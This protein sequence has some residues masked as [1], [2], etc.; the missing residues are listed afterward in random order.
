MS[1]PS[2]LLSER[3]SAAPD[4]R[5]R[6]RRRRKRSIAPRTAL[7]SC[8]TQLTGGQNDLKD[9]SV[10]IARRRADAAIVSFDDRPAN[11][12]TY[13]HA[14]GLRRVERLKNAVDPF[15]IDTR[16]RVFHR[17]HY[18]IRFARFR[19]HPQNAWALRYGAHGIDRVRNQIQED[20]LQLD[21][22]AQDLKRFC[23]KFGL[24]RNLLVLQL[25]L[26][27]RE[28]L[29]DQLVQVDRSSFLTIFLE[30]RSDRTDNLARTMTV[31]DDAR[32]R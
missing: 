21:A 32:Q 1:Q 25:A 7:S 18:A 26:H 2:I 4:V 10:R 11:S 9:R 8:S 15:R 14:L 19:F 3:G 17:D 5:T 24:E 6:H 31:V 13:A 23:F 28:D 29:L 27:K 12:Q 16:P 20:L 30:H 22:I